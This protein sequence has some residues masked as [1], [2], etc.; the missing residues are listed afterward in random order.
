MNRTVLTK[1]TRPLRDFNKKRARNIGA[2]TP[3]TLEKTAALADRSR[4]VPHVLPE[5]SL[6]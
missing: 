5:L 3:K 4:G 1:P 2:V 6:G